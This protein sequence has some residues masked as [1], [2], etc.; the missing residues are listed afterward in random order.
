M[1]LGHRRRR[2]L[3]LHRLSARQALRRGVEDP[4]HIRHAPS[5]PALGARI[6]ELR[7]QPSRPFPAAQVRP[8]IGQGAE[9]ADVDGV[10]G[11]L[12]ARLAA[13][14]PHGARDIRH[15]RE[16]DGIPRG[17]LAAR[18]GLDNGGE[19]A[20]VRRQQVGAGRELATPPGR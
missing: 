13:E 1:A 3:S 11:A 14:A 10:G 6:D 18:P 15:R 16:R 4:Q 19:R 9:C 12:H 7:G 8:S 17:R 5:P 20:K 2:A